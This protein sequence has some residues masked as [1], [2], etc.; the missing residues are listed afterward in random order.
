MAIKAKINKVTMNLTDYYLYVQGVQ[1]SGKTTLFRDLV[2]KLHG[3]AENGL[4]LAIG[5]E[6]GYKALDNIQAL[7][8]P[9]WTTFS[10]VIDDLIED[11]AGNEHIKI[12]CVDTLDELVELAEKETIRQSRIQTGKDCKTLNSALGGYGAGRKYLCKIVDDYLC[13]LHEAGYGLLVLSHT[14]LRNVKEQGTTEEMEYQV[15][16]SNLNS[17]YANIV[18]HKA[19]VCSTITIE[20][21]VNENGRV[22]DTKRWIY[23]RG[24]G[25]VNAGSRFSGIVDKVE[26]SV[27]NFVKA[28]EDG[29]K[30]SITVPMSDEELKQEELRQAKEKEERLK[31][32]DETK[33]EFDLDRNAELIK[34]ITDN[35]SKLDMANMK[36]IMDKYSVESFANPDVVPT[37]CLEEIVRLIK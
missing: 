3:K 14:K 35:V 21:E 33:N 10:E 34:F 30:N 25:F 26:L 2:L 13:R 36:E 5:K 7:D 23:F 24:N 11:R 32:L 17:D 12:V 8:V 6:K 22:T 28:I 4:L 16:D 20:R 37:K 1:K 29:I 18:L 9:D 15:L 27:D 31:K 19:D